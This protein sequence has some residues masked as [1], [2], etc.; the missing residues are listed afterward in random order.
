MGNDPVSGVDPSGLWPFA[1]FSPTLD[2]PITGFQWYENWGGPSWANGS[3]TSEI[4]LFPHL[5]SDPL[6]QRPTNMRDYC[7]YA[8]DICLHNQSGILDDNTRQNCRKNCDR[9]LAG[10]LSGVPSSF[11]DL[12]GDLVKSFEINLFNGNFG[13]SPS[14][15]QGE[16][17]LSYLNQEIYPTYTPQQLGL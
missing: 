8:H 13:A 2:R 5:L 16:N 15:N 6:F 10:C 1:I 4:D 12:G 17:P 9:K 3:K 14:D 7:Y 11:W